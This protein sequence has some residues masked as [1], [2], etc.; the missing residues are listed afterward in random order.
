[1]TV[2]EILESYKHVAV[3]GLSEKRDR[4]SHNVTKYLIH[5]GYTIYPVNPNLDKV[6]GITCYPSLLDI[7]D[8][9]R[10]NIEIV[11]IFRKAE[12]VDRIV[13]EAIE[14]GAKVIWMQL[15]IINDK[16]AGKARE[17]G[18][19]VVENQCMAVEHHHLF[20]T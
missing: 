16:A 7:P 17:A 19:E 18:L 14:I 20:D 9:K 15:G 4:P 12:H 6:F 2:K 8:E 10:K 3:V 11:D 5:A 1:M 13:D